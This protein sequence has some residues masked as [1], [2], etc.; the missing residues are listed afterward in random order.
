MLKAEGI[1]KKKVE[2]VA[3]ITK[4][5]D[6]SVI[7]PRIEVPVRSGIVYNRS[8]LYNAGNYVSY[9]IND[10]TYLESIGYFI[11]NNLPINPKSYARIDKVAG[12]KP[13]KLID[14]NAFGNKERYTDRNGEHIYPDDYLIDHL[15][16]LG[17]WFKWND[18]DGI[19]TFAEYC[20]NVLP[21][22]TFGGFTGWRMPTYKAISSLINFRNRVILNN[23][24]VIYERNIQHTN[25]HNTV[26]FYFTTCSGVRTANE[27]IMQKEYYGNPSR[28][29]W[30][31]I[32]TAANNNKYIPMRIHYG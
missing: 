21:D 10:D 1:L 12:E 5:L 27:M 2:G 8:M 30:T 7:F 26:S 3:V 25:T 29:N 6:V 20:T 9:F 19:N 15:T 17:W 4:R 31:N 22:K 32:Y 11:Q 16:G 28:L 23:P 13:T 24:D 18:F 14:N